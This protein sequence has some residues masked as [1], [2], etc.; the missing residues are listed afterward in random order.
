[1]RSL[2]IILR[3]LAYTCVHFVETLGCGSLSGIPHFGLSRQPYQLLRQGL[4]Y[5]APAAVWQGETLNIYNIFLCAYTSSCLGNQ[6]QQVLNTQQFCSTMF[7]Y[8]SRNFRTR[9]TC[10]LVCN[11]NR[12]WK[13]MHPTLQ[14]FWAPLLSSH[15]PLSYFWEHSRKQKLGNT[16]KESG[17][18]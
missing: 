2:T 8:S 17:L 12:C 16:K 1:M 15:L 14:Y 13:Q 10:F 3:I 7:I 9:S 4:P 11:G 5:P 18:T 6:G